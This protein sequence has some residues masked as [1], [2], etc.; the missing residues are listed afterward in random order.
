MSNALRAGASGLATGPDRFA[1]DTMSVARK[2]FQ[3]A[4]ARD[5]T[6]PHTW[7]SLSGKFVQAP[8]V[9]CACGIPAQ[10]WVRRDGK[11]YT[12]SSQSKRESLLFS[13]LHPVRERPGVNLSLGE[14]DQRPVEHVVPE[15]QLEP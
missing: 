4:R 10:G 13:Q 15:L 8:L 3:A 1:L 14:R 7:M 9:V 2:M 12:D 11:N 6:S 5:L